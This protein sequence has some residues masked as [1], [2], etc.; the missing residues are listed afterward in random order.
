M[1]NQ[2]SL[3]ASLNLRSTLFSILL[4]PLLTYTLTFLKSEYALRKQTSEQVPPIVPYWFPFLGN[5]IHF[6]RDAPGFAAHIT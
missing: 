4:I 1:D 6:A 3:L 5:V 2:F